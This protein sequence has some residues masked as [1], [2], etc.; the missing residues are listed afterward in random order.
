MRTE[1]LLADKKFQIPDGSS[2]SWCTAATKAESVSQFLEAYV[3][4]MVDYDPEKAFVAKQ[5]HFWQQQAFLLKE[6]WTRV[7]S[8]PIG[9]GIEVDRDMMFMV[10]VRAELLLKDR[11][12]ISEKEHMALDKAKE[13]FE[14]NKEQWKRQ[15]GMVVDTELMMLRG[16]SFARYAYEKG[17]FTPQ[18]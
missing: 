10:A 2:V 4:S 12:N 9:H 3:R 15:Y 1:A 17:L 11:E 6:M 16:K 5:L 18:E 7:D 13:A 14:A 8:T